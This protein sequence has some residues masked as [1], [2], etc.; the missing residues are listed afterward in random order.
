M[1]LTRPSIDARTIL[2]RMLTGAL[3]AAAIATLAACG[4]DGGSD[5]GSG[6]TT[7]TPASE[8]RPIDAPAQNTPTTRCAP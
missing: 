8:L 5:S 6:G 4:G 2:R 3:C 7:A 1:N